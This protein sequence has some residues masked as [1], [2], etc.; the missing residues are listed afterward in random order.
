MKTKVFIALLLMSLV[1]LAGTA[2]EKD[3]KFGIELNGGLSFAMNKFAESLKPG[4]GAEALFHYRFM[5]HT[6]VYAGWGANWLS[7]ENPDSEPNRDYEETG[8]V[9]GVQ[10]KH[11]IQGSRSS[12]FVRAGVLYNHIEVENDNKE[13]LDD[14]GHGPGLQLA[15]GM[16]INLGSSW[17]LA[18][19]VQYQSLKRPLYS[20]GSQM[21]TRFSHLSLRVGILKMF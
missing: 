19:Y 5:P 12:Y 9:L 8:Y 17:H 6:G 3:S 21:D 18:P 10:F 11:P 4:F 13:T 16:D 2:Q 7:T 15:A 1:P 20:E 14:T